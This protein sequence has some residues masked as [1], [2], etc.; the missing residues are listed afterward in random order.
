MDE[1][2]KRKLKQQ[3]SPQQYHVVVEKG[4]EPPFSGVWNAHFQPG[5][6][7]CV[8]CGEP[9]FL[10]ANK[11]DAGCGWPSFDRALDG[12]VATAEDNS[13]GM[14]RTEITC[15]NCGAHLGHVFRDGPTETGIR[16]CVNSL[17]LDFEPVDPA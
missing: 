16:H 11:F 4:T 3:L 12:K 15:G 8:A 7:R 9:L 6:Y 10:G 13:L 2:T 14:R 5:T 17:A 1:T